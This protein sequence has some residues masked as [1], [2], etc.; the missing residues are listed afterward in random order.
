MAYAVS[1]LFDGSLADAVAQHWMR[2]A[3][4]NVSRSMPDLGYPPHVTLAVYDMLRT[5]VA[6]VALDRVFESASRMAVTLTGV[7]TFGTGSGVL[8]AALDASPELQRLQAATVAAIGEVCH[9]HY[10]TE[11]WTPHCTLATGVNDSDLHRGK[12]LLGK[13]WRPLTGMFE[14]AALVEFIPVAEIKRWALSRP[15]RSTRTP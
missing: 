9:P 12:D 13:H 11:S 10:R 3:D 6:A 1:L 8:Y 2:L 4:A 7:A 15:P 5:D 14:D